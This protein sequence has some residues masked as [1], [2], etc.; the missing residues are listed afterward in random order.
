MHFFQVTVLGYKIYLYLCTRFNLHIMKEYELN[1]RVK[2]LMPAELE[3]SDA[4]LVEAAKQA[5]ETSYSPYSHFQVGAALRMESGEIIK[6]S[7]QENASYPVSC[8]AERTALFWAGANRPGQAV[9]A[10]AIAAQSKGRFTD[11]VTGPCGVCRQALLE[12][13][14]RQGSPI[15][16]LLYSENGVHVTDSIEEIVPFSFYAESMGSEE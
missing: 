14:H 6:G 9:R 4:E 12:V 10:I 16:L 3:K 8:C 1:V 13:E 11:D 5:T 2:V 7:N 15:R